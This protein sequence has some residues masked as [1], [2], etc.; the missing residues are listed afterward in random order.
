MSRRGARLVPTL[1]LAAALG[2][3]GEPP[4]R[5]GHRWVVVGLDGLDPDTVELLW[6]RGEL[7]HLRAIAE[8][9]TWTVL[10]TRYTA[11]PII[12]TT[13]ATGM[14]P[15]RHGIL[16]FVAAGERGDVPV[17]SGLRRVPAIWNMLGGTGLEVAVVGWWASWP[18]EAVDGVVVSD[19]VAREGL[20]R[21]FSPESLAGEVAAALEAAPREGALDLGEHTNEQDRV[22]SLL[23]ERL[24]ADDAFDLVLT[25]FRAVDPTSH[26]D[27]KYFHPKRYDPADVDPER[28]E[29]HSDHVPAAYRASD[30]LVGR[31][32]AAAGP[33]ANLM[34]LSD[35]GFRA[36]IPPE[37][38]LQSDLDPLL[39]RLGWLV[40]DPE[41]GVDREASRAWTHRTASHDRFK[42]IRLRRVREIPP[43][44][45]L[46]RRRRTEEL[47]EELAADLA[48]VTYPG[49]ERAASVRLPR[50]AER[51]RRMAGADAVVTLHPDG[52][53]TR[54]LVDGEP[55]EGVVHGVHEVSGT[56]TQSTHGV[57]FATGPDVAPG[58]D[59][60]GMRI[61]DVTPTLLYALG[62]PVAEDFAGRAW[63]RLVREEL[64][65]R[66]PD[67][68]V[69]TY[70]EREA[71]DA[72]ATG[73][74][75]EMIEELR[76]LGY[77]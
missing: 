65:D 44:R 58:A 10:R 67:E 41:G 71:T 64:A 50:P 62:L 45:E 21:R 48:A 26:H 51:R 20:P 7:P 28:L 70:G 68:T 47:I 15:A 34:V 23:A 60:S 63:K 19:R 22:L 76:A 11:S 75:E 46:E 16:D 33:E 54:L 24:A 31:I 69:A 9:G 53:S 5:P 3:G 12:W 72:E 43:E 57:L 25:Y 74:D 6:E 36:Q 77:L 37:L 55:L 38:T 52:V 35:H 14:P 59:L 49:G 27:W 66:L 73:E 29:R 56:H 61:H 30:E 2:C 4:E 1:L 39:E 18:A 17:S 8:R 42:R 13:I 40:R 32:A